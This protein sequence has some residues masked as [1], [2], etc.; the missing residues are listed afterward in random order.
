MLVNQGVRN[1]GGPGRFLGG[2]TAASTERGK[3]EQPGN[4]RNF[5]AGDA[6]VTTNAVTAKAGRPWGYRH[7][8]A[9]L[10]PQ[11]PGAV[12]TYGLLA[13]VG[14]TA[15][16]NL[17]GGKAAAAGL[18]GS[19]DLTGVGALI[20]SAVAAILGSGTVMDADARAFLNAAADLDGS[21][22]VDAALVA[23]GH[24]V[25]A[26]AGSCAVTPVVR[27]DGE[28]D[29]DLTPFTDLSPQ[30]LAS[31]VWSS[32]EGAFLYA[33]AHNRI[34]TDPV[35]GTFTVYDDDGV[36]VLYVADLWQDAAGATPY[37]GSGA[38]RRDAFA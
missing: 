29:A 7:P 25:A 37:A 26:L 22:D 1:G 11:K 15:G 18:T 16:G 35:A 21:G 23:V 31:A 32:A 33:L 27:A 20:V 3:W 30:S 5:G 19:G 9:W 10:L 28:L 12:S 24:A 6:R 4:L 34:V 36:T 13:G 17:A 38:D 2:V 14:E 8:A